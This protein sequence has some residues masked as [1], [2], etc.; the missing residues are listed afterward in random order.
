MDFAIIYMRE[1]VHICV[2]IYVKTYIYYSRTSYMLRLRNITCAYVITTVSELR[3]WPRGAVRQS[4]DLRG[5]S[6]RGVGWQYLTG[7]T[8][9]PTAGYQNLANRLISGR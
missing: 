9:H 7:Q 6:G 4:R 5:I 1:Y 8:Q 2:Y 3:N